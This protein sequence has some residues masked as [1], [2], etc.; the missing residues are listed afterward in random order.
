MP[1][2]T[3]T[4]GST[5]SSQ[6]ADVPESGG[7]GRSGSGVST[8]DAGPRAGVRTFEGLRNNRFADPGRDT[9]SGSV[10]G[11]STSGASFGARSGA[12]TETAS[13]AVTPSSPPPAVTD[14]VNVTTTASTN[15]VQVGMSPQR[16]EIIGVFDFPSCFKGGKP[17]PAAQLIDVQYQFKQ[18]GYTTVASM[19]SPYI[20]GLRG[21]KDSYDEIQASNEEILGVY[22]SILPAFQALLD[23]LNFGTGNSRLNEQLVAESAFLGSQVGTLEASSAKLYTDIYT[24]VYNKSLQNFL[25]D[26]CGLDRR[27]VAGLSNTAYYMQSCHELENI[28]RY[29]LIPSQFRS[30][31]STDGFTTVGSSYAAEYAGI[32]TGLTAVSS[33]ADI[34]SNQIADAQRKISKVSSTDL[35][36]LHSIVYRNTHGDPLIK[37]TTNSSIANIDDFI[38]KLIIDY[39]P[40]DVIGQNQTKS[41][42]SSRAYSRTLSGNK[43]YLPLETKYIS[44]DTG[45]IETGR[46]VLID[47]LMGSLINAGT[48]QGSDIDAY[49]EFTTKMRSADDFSFSTTQASAITIISNVFCEKDTTYLPKSIQSLYACIQQFRTMISGCK[50]SGGSASY[51]DLFII[52]MLACADSDDILLYRISR[53][54]S[55]RSRSNEFFAGASSTSE[56]SN[57]RTVKS[58]SLTSL[59]DH[60]QTIS[61]IVGKGRRL[62]N[63]ALSSDGLAIEVDTGA[64]YGLS[65]KPADFIVSALD[66]DDGPFSYILNAVL[67]YITSINYRYGSTNPYVG[68]DRVDGINVDSIIVAFTKTF[69]SL[70]RSSITI[71]FAS[72]PSSSTTSTSRAPGSRATSF[73]QKQ[74]DSLNSIRYSKIEA[75]HLVN[76]CTA[77]LQYKNSQS[78]SLKIEE[79][80][81]DQIGRQ[82]SRAFSDRLRV[83]IDRL[84]TE[85]IAI[86]YLVDTFWGFSYGVQGAYV[87]VADLITSLNSSTRTGSGSREST[88]EEL[89]VTNQSRIRR[90][91]VPAYDLDYFVSNFSVDQL[92]TS[93]A[94]NK[95]ASKVSLDHPAYPI[96]KTLD[97]NEL[98][99]LKVYLT[100]LDRRLDALSDR[101]RILAVGIPAGMLTFLRD[102]TGQKSTFTSADE[103]SSSDES[104]RII[105]RVMARNQRKDSDPIVVADFSFDSRVFVLGGISSDD[106]TVKDFSN[107]ADLYKGTPFYKV[108]GVSRVEKISPARSN[109]GYLINHF[110][111]HYCKI[112]LR[113]LTGVDLGEQ[114]FTFDKTVTKHSPDLTKLD[115]FAGMLDLLSSRF[116]D[117][118]STPNFRDAIARTIYFNE[119]LYRSRPIYTKMF[120]RIFCIPINLDSFGL[121]TMKSSGDDI[122]MKDLFCVVYMN[123][124]PQASVAPPAEVSVSIPPTSPDTGQV[125]EDA[126]SG[127]YDSESGRLG[128]VTTGGDT[129]TAQPGDVNIRSGIEASVNVSAQTQAYIENTIVGSMVKDMTQNM[130]NESIDRGQEIVGQA[131]V[132]TTVLDQIKNE[133][134]VNPVVEVQS[135]VQN[136]NNVV[137]ADFVSNQVKPVTS[138]KPVKPATNVTNQTIQT[139]KNINNVSPSVQA[140]KPA[141]EL[142]ANLATTPVTDSVKNLTQGTKGLAQSANQNIAQGVVSV[143]ASNY[144][145]AMTSNF[146]AT[147]SEIS[148]LT[149]SVTKSL[150][151]AKQIDTQNNAAITKKIETNVATISSTKS[152][153]ASVTSSAVKSN[154]VVSSVSNVQAMQNA[155]QVTQTAQ[156]TQNIANQATQSVA[157]QAAQSVASNAASSAAS[158][159]A[160]SARNASV[161]R[162]SSAAAK[163]YTNRRK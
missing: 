156:V 141:S 17:T 160:A 61:G 144:Q 90:V 86:K 121:N 32:I 116:P 64:R 97:A 106:Y 14:Y 94:M 76:A 133:I 81:T 2:K 23:A 93:I 100:N 52:N 13:T 22:E 98:H 46:K 146:N 78:L 129:G 112:F 123:S 62:V 66:R 88:L 83:S 1:V 150:E 4:F 10:P 108:S 41:N 60:I 158:N 38:T 161:T 136:I 54:I 119:N 142:N 45:E 12:S 77:L 75:G 95:L 42:I 50:L 63:R 92:L 96:S 53:F 7:S 74:S 105:V 47:S 162:Q 29:G 30:F 59:S 132:S 87:R 145:N 65:L 49:R 28:L 80:V 16:P 6:P 82:Y 159:V 139:V 55:A 153:T 20:D 9:W 68:Y 137:S 135:V 25:Q 84:L 110:N 101:N 130:I 134:N 21:F 120:D 126:L 91:P 85:E 67:D 70:V 131:L 26:V 125:K 111:D 138:V 124:V 44:S 24:T 58:K 122:D 43:I 103:V 33:V 147:K 39:L 163:T 99:N 15:A 109:L 157:S 19:M 34:N 11:D 69:A 48:A 140:V 114:N 40:G 89:S 152:V 57:S 113:A 118:Y 31:A 117:L 51:Q 148:N 127:F 27:F 128:Q 73:Y 3:E 102:Q 18:S 5:T 71:D 115:T 149:T 56:R 155:N 36:K 107:L 35:S 143:K 154:Q 37:Q 8:P 104:F 79:L 72:S 151:S